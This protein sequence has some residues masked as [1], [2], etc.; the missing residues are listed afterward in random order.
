MMADVRAPPLRVSL[1]YLSER[2]PKV[3]YIYVERSFY[4]PTCDGEIYEVNDTDKRSSSAT[5]YEQDRKKGRVKSSMV[6]E[7]LGFNILATLL[8]GQTHAGYL[9]ILS[10]VCP[11]AL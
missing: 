5:R 7:R 9:P 2:S 4:T 10:P 3:V 6:R 8:R 1:L 11:P